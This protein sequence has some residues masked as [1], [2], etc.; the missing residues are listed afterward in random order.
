MKT[1][2]ITATIFFSLQSTAA[3]WNKTVLSVSNNKALS[4][5]EF[6]T[7]LTKYDTVV[8]SE[9]HYTKEVQIAEGEI[10]DSVVTAG[11]FQSD[12]TFGWEFLNVSEQLKIDKL[13]LDLKVGAMTSD[14]FTKATQGAAGVIYAPVIDAVAKNDGFILGL[15]LSRA[16]KSPVTKGGLSAAD[17]KLVPKDYAPGSFNYRERFDLVMSGHVPASVLNNYWDA[18]C[19]TD[20]VMANTYLSEKKGSIGFLVMGSFHAE[21]FDGTVGRLNLR[22]PSNK[23]AVVQIV[24]ASDYTET[25]LADIAHDAKYGNIADYLYFVN[26]PY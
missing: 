20:D 12:F 16:E 26:E 21:Y 9:K 8:L 14:D 1:L 10:I 22:D 13:A 23:I 15:N 3:G 6:T 4:I 18:Q 11:G 24:D 17:P 2:F 7:T 19:L 25:E 5:N